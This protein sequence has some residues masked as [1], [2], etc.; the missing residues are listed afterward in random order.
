LVSKTI[1]L[2]Q[3]IDR[4]TAVLNEIYTKTI[5][6]SVF[7]SKHQITATI[8]LKM[9]VVFSTLPEILLVDL[10]CYLQCCQIKSLW[11][12]WFRC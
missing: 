3:T 2:L 6:F 12:T 11:P 8:Y 1:K 10:L 9:M 7:V 4:A 5:P